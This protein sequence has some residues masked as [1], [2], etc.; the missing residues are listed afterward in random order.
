MSPLS[1]RMFDRV[2]PNLARDRQ[3]L[4]PDRLGF[5]YSDRLQVPLAFEEYALATLDALDAVGINQFDAFGVHTGSCEVIE[6]AV[7]HADRVRRA[8]MVAI[9]AFSV[10]EVKE[11]KGKYMAPPPVA[12]DGSHHTWAWNWWREWQVKTPGWD[13]AVLQADVMDHVASWPNI[14]W[15]YHAVFDYP[16]AARIGRVTQPLLV[17]ASHNDLWPQTQHGKEH[18]PPHAEFVDL[19]HLTLEIFNVATDEV[20]GQIRAFLA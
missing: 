9:P 14:W 6:L 4:V 17:L 15:T 11:F 12:A 3:V 13:L 2:L 1:G 20:A 10:A 8:G 18:L 16:T 7:A 5:G 19:P